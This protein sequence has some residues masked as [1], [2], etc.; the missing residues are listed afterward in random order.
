MERWCT[1]S[2][3]SDCR[4][5][6]SVSDLNP[7]LPFLHTTV[8][9]CHDRRV[10]REGWGEGDLNISPI[11]L[12]RSPD[13][14]EYGSYF[15]R[16]ELCGLPLSFLPQF[17]TQDSHLCSKG[18]MVSTTI[19]KAEDKV[20]PFSSGSS[21]DLVQDG[22]VN[23]TS[24]TKSDE[25]PALRVHYRPPGRFPSGRALPRSA[26]SLFRT[27]CSSASGRLTA[28]VLQQPRALWRGHCGGRRRRAPQRLA[29]KREATASIPA[30]GASATARP[31]RR[32]STALNSAPTS[33]TIAT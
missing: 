14:I 19:A 4:E 22:R 32:A 20:D 17:L 6:G 3:S 16:N 8:H 25:E 1:V 9:H 7:K 33:R 18:S 2:D 21:S 10:W 5:S 11:L 23:L 31:R 27:N 12:H 30:P 15:A 28:T 13:I 26:T 24:C 29:R